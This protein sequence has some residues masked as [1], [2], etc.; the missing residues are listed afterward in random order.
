MGNVV[1]G[2]YHI[3]LAPWVIFPRRQTI[4][5]WCGIFVDPILLVALKNQPAGVDYS[6]F[7]RPFTKS[8]WLAILVFTTFLGLFILIPFKWN[9]NFDQ[10][11]SCFIL[12]TTSWYY[13]LVI[14][15]FYGGALTMFFANE[16]SMPFSSVKDV[17]NAYPGNFKVTL[18]Y[19]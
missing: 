7:L 1:N 18:D 13:F 15:S 14:Q 4:L 8:S 19:R 17:I 5:D 2:K 9:S 3:T 11:N 12:K 10:A 6:L 16:P